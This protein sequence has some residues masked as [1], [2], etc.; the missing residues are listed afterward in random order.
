MAE[1]SDPDVSPLKEPSSLADRVVKAT[2]SIAI[3]HFIAKIMGVVAS[4]FIGHY[5]GFGVENDAF[6]FA[7][8]ILIWSFFL[9]GEESLGPAFLPIFM[10]S[11]SKGSEKDAWHFT[12]VVMNLQIL[13]LLVVIAALML[14]PQQVVYWFTRFDRGVA[15]KVAKLSRADLAIH[16]ITWMAP[17]LLG[18]SISSLTYMILNGYKKFFWPA[19]ADAALKAGLVAGVLMGRLAGWDE[20]ALIAGVLVA[21]VIKLGV[22]VS[23]LGGK[24][25]M[26][27]PTLD[28]SNPWLRKMVILIAPLLLG[29][30]YAKGRDYFN[31]AYVISSL[32]AGML[33]VNRYGKKIFTTMGWLIPYPLSIAMFPFLCELVDRK[34]NVALGRFLTKASRMLL[35][36]FFPMAAVIAVLSIPLAQ[37][38]FQT[39]KVTAADA[40][41]AGQVNSCYILVL[42]AY[43]LEYIFMQAYFSTRR[44]AAVALIGVI[45][46]TLSMVISYVCVLRLGFTGAEAVMAVALGYTLSRWLKTLTLIGVLK[47]SGLQMLPLGPMVVYLG[48]VVVLTACCAGAAYGALAGFSRAQDST[49]KKSASL[50]ETAAV[51]NGEQKAEIP[52]KE[53]GNPGKGAASEAGKGDEKDRK[54]SGGSAFRALLSAGPRLIVPGILAVMV[55][56]LGWKVM[57]FEE[58]DEMLHYTKEKLKRRRTKV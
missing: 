4:R 41:L 26:L 40:A 32:E 56:I 21:S 23:A 5:Y 30:L 35:L 10:E 17:A 49:E 44:T 15:S 16:Y 55:F 27:R 7:Y 28:F 12:S 38:L 50:R 33:S 18:L 53:T 36:I 20:D 51:A 52:G 48:R 46:S 6:L 11:R 43:A 58:L 25:K 42:P 34:D 39:G 37:V 57:R 19:F 2:V 45:F 31:D 1:Q 13:I 24:I 3:A 8:E 54:G 22:H 9:I 29:I 14:F 47:A